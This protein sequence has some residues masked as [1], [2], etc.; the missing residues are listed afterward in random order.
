[1]KERIRAGYHRLPYRHV[2]KLMII[3][4]VMEAARKL[5]FFPTRNGISEY[6]SPHAILHQLP[7]HYNKDCRFTYGKYV[8]AAHDT[9]NTQAARTLDCIYLRSLGNRQGGHQLLHLRTNKVITRHAVTSTTI[10]P[11]VIR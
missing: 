5:N 9:T 3:H 8:Q 7:I 10:T 11:S 1:M 4:Q 6:Y 2:P